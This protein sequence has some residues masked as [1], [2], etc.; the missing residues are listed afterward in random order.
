M[1]DSRD[2]TAVD[3]QVNEAITRQTNLGNKGLIAF[4]A[5]GR[6]RAPVYDLYL[7]ALRQINSTLWSAEYLTNLTLIRSLSSTPW[8]P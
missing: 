1:P 4:G 2:H 3:R 7:P 8:A 6:L 5:L